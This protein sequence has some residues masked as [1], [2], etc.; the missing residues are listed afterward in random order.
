MLHL[1][2]HQ[3]MLHEHGWHT[4]NKTEPATLEG[5]DKWTSVM[6]YYSERELSKGSDRLAAISGY[7]KAVSQELEDAGKSATYIAG[8]WLAENA[9]VKRQLAWILP[10]STISFEQLLRHHTDPQQYIAPS[11]SWAALNQPVDV[12]SHYTTVY[13]SIFRVVSHSILP[14]RSDPTV[15]VAPGSS[16]TLFGKLRKIPGGPC[17]GTKTEMKAGDRIDAIFWDAPY[18]GDKKAWRRWRR[19]NRDVGTRISY[20]LDWDHSTDDP[21]DRD[22]EAHLQLFLLAERHEPDGTETSYGLILHPSVVDPSSFLRV[23]YFTIFGPSESPAWKETE[24]V[25]I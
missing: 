24:V 8:I 19:G 9:S 1:R 7:V 23:G 12:E 13:Q 14:A 2:C 15:A 20:S 18:D 25:V 3:R 16:I 4:G 10:T 6:E 11:W 5:P 21:A 22:P 17:L